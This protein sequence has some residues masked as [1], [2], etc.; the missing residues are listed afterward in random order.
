MKVKWSKYVWGFL[1]LMLGF[2]VLS[3]L[4]FTFQAAEALI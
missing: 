2:L 4:V 1:L 3:Y